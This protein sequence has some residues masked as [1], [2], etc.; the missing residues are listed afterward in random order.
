MLILHRND[1]SSCDNATLLCLRQCNMLQF[2]C[3]G[4][5]YNLC[6][7]HVFILSRIHKKRSSQPHRLIIVTGIGMDMKKRLKV[8]LEIVAWG[9][10]Q[11]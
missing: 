6:G 11:T 1:L 9:A 5:Y 3:T 4:I 10:R 2:Q 8:D 7:M